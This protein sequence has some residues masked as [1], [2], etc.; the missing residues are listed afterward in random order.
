MPITIENWKELN[1]EEIKK[2]KNELETFDDYVP[3]IL[4]NPISSYK[5][6][7]YLRE[8]E[9]FQKIRKINKDKRMEFKQTTDKINWIKKDVI[10]FTNKYPEYEVL[11]KTK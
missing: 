5:R 1:I 9:L 10:E 6:Y 8:S 3:L 7:T 11:V 4:L 2:H